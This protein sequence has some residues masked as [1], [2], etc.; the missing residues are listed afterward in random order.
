VGLRRHLIEAAPVPCLVMRAWMVWPALLLVAACGSS[1]LVAGTPAA[2]AVQ[3]SDLPKGLQ[4]CNASGDIESFLSAIMSKDPTTYQKTKAEWEGAKSSGASA[5]QVAFYADTTAHCAGI[6]SSDPTVL[7]GATYPVVLN[8][9]IEFKDESS[10]SAGYA[11][12]SIFGFSQAK[13]CASGS[14]VT[15][16]KDTGLTANSCVLTLAIEKQSIY[17]ADWQNKAF[18]VI[19]AVVNV[20]VAQSKKIA[21]AENTRI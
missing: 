1:G 5:A 10:A 17:L 4:R 3:A 15:T 14:A 7:A 8:F 21:I 20:D 16:G 6:Q 2:I 19:L 12:K 9:V 13:V 11:S 18:I